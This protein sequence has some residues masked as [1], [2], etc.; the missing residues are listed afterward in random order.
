LLRDFPVNLIGNGDYLRLTLKRERRGDGKADDCHF[1]GKRIR[2]N[3]LFAAMH[4]SAFGTKLT[5][6]TAVVLC[7]PAH[8]IP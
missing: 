6:R 5:Q 7:P 4:M 3:V 2:V 1:A 8:V